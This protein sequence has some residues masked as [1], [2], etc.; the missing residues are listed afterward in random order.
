MNQDEDYKAVARRNIVGK[1]QYTISK[2][3]NPIDKTTS[4][5]TP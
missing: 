3:V 2:V 1:G 4:M 5:F